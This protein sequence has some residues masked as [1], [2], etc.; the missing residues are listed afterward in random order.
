MGGTTDEP[1][2][3][4]DPLLT[5]QVGDAVRRVDLDQLRSHAR[6]Y[7]FGSARQ[8]DILTIDEVRARLELVSVPEEVWG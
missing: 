2:P 3:V 7:G 4:R 8:G 6:E 5:R 1:M